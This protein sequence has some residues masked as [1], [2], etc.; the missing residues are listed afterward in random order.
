MGTKS[1]INLNINKDE[2][3]INDF[4]Y[5]WDQF[6]SRPNKITIH[7]NYQTKLFNVAIEEYK[8]GKN[9]FTEVIPADDELIINDK[10]LLKISD[11]IY[12]SYVVVDRL[13]DSSMVTDI[14]FYFKEEED[15]ELVNDIIDLLNDCL[16]DYTEEESMNLNTISL[17]QNGLEIEPINNQSIDNDNLDSYYNGKTFK[18]LQKLVKKVKK[19]NKGLSIL[20][21]QKGTG[22]TAA[23]NYIADNLDR[24]VFFIP[25]NLIEH[26]INNPDFRKFLKKHHKPI[27]IIDDCEMIFNEY[28]AKSNVVVN[29]LLQLV[30]GFLSD[31]LEVNIITIFN[32]EEEDEID[33]TLLDCNN[34]IE[35]VEF[36]YLEDDEATELSRILGHSKKYKNKT[37]LIDI[38][39]KRNGSIENRIGF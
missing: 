3:S 24:I 18:E 25:N 6:S 22:K 14:T 9:V 15:S 33:H 20:W 27:I 13:M 31:D 10:I 1:N 39:K 36:E 21:G 7:N 11:N 23:I 30:D 17:N 34:L 19:N 29:N 28:F 8:N 2:S 38:I 37:K 4:L 26:T 5:C 32:V 16:L 12:L 35:V